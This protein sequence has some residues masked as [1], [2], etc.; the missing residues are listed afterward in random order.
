VLSEL[1]A[2]K[3]NGEVQTGWGSRKQLTV[4]NALSLQK[5]KKMYRGRE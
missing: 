3:G 1:E 4:H 5:K 2:S